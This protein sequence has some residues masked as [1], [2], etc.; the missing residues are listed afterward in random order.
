[1]NEFP[2]TFAASRDE[3]ERIVVKPRLDFGKGRDTALCTSR[4]RLGTT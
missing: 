4:R 2:C 3:F 1:M